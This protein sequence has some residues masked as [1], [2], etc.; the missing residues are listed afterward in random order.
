VCGDGGRL[1]V[2]DRDSTDFFFFFFNL[3]NVQ[4]VIRCTRKVLSFCVR[5]LTVAEFYRYNLFSLFFK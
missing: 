3:I 1:E 2:T 4:Y 5:F